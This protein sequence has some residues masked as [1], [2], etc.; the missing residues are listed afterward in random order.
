MEY[1]G[2]PFILSFSQRFPE[3][4]VLQSAGREA[5][6]DGPSRTRRET[7][8]SLKILQARFGSSDL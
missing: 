7:H 4:V 2:I 5:R 6:L 8:R 3:T 1:T